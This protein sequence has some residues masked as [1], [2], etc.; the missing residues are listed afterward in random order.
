MEIKDAIRLERV[1]ESHS[2]TEGN[3]RPDNRNYN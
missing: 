2:L 3:W 1:K